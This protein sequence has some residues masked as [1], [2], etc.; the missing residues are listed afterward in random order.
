MNR[1]EGILVIILAALAFITIIGSASA[2]ETPVNQVQSSNDCGFPENWTGNWTDYWPFPIQPWDLPEG[3][4]TNASGFIASSEPLQAI[5]VIS[6]TII[7][8]NSSNES[9]PYHPGYNPDIENNMTNET[10]PFHPGYDWDHENSV[11]NESSPYHPGYNPDIENNM[12]NETSPF[13]PGYNPDIENGQNI[14][15]CSEDN[16]VGSARIWD[17]IVDGISN[18]FTKLAP[19]FYEIWA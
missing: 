14:N 16:D 18:W 13:H 15:L 12:T 2:A 5:P 9:S 4:I 3:N 19:Y 7:R 11:D 17:I 10:S 6:H 1:Q 8:D